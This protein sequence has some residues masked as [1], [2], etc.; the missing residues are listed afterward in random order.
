MN[1]QTSSKNC[2]K[3]QKFAK[4]SHFSVNFITF[5]AK[6]LPLALRPRLF[7]VSILIIL[8]SALLYI[9]NIPVSNVSAASI[10][11]TIPKTLTLNVNPVAN[12]GFAKSET[13]GKITVATDNSVGYTLSIKAKNESNDLL[14]GNNKIVSI[15]NN[16]SEDNFKNS[17]QSNIWGFLPSKLY[18]TESQTSQDN[19][20]FIPGPKNDKDTT[21][22]VTD[23]SNTEPNSYN[24]SLGAKVDSTIPSGSYSNT[25]IISAT[26]NEL[27]YEKMQNWEGCDSLG[28]EQTITLIDSRDNKHYTVAK[29]KDGKC[30]MTQ[31][32]ALGKDG[33]M[34]LTS[35]DS[36]VSSDYTLPASSPSGFSDDSAQNIYVTPAPDDN[37]YGGY[38][39]WLAAT[40]GTNPSSGEASSSICP[41][42]WRLPTNAEFSA[43]T[44]SY[45][46]TTAQQAPANFVLAGYYD[47]S[48]PHVQGTRGFWWSSTAVSSGTKAYHLR[49]WPDFSSFFTDNHYKRYGSSIRCVSRSTDPIGNMQDVGIWGAFVEKGQSVQAVDTRDNKTYTVARLEDGKLW[50]TQ[51]LGIGSNDRAT[52]LDPDNTD[53]SQLYTLPQGSTTGFSDNS[54]QN[55]Y[56]TPTPDNNRYGGYYT[57]AAATAGTNPSSGESSSSI[58]PK[59][60]R[61]PTKAE[62]DTLVNSYNITS[63]QQAPANFVLAGYYSNSSPILQGTGSLWWSSTAGDSTNAYYLYLWPDYSSF[64]IPNN[65][66]RYGGSIRCIS[67]FDFPAENMQDMAGMDTDGQNRQVKGRKCLDGR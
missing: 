52:S 66:K 31:N 61:L 20:D 14:N 32:L 26:T 43:L 67:E 13:P 50:M 47:S 53:I 10:T 21:I 54:A 18:N 1:R 33:T 29:L 36:D 34:T 23:S 27:P 11:L 16:L 25:F 3:W 5:G 56:I 59:G 4:T 35:S 38:Y 46:S 51:N 55:I 44:K 22:D 64:V 17:E 24:I 65:L 48:S 6:L 30:W 45:D 41:K 2:K 63:I 7:D 12:N 60:W 28:D 49:L 62:F 15:S 9:V 57:Y 40:A 37:Y 19:S 39:T 42:G 58:C 8:I